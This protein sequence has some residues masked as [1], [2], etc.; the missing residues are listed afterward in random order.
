LSEAFDRWWARE[1]VVLLEAPAPDGLSAFDG[2]LTAILERVDPER[3]SVV[4]VGPSEPDG[5]PELTVAALR[6]P[7][8]EPG[9]LRSAFTR[10]SGVVGLVDVA[11]TLLDQFGIE[12][13][14][15]M[16]G[17]AFVRGREG[18]DYEDR[19]DWLVDT[20]LRARFRDR[21]ITQ[22]NGTFVFC[23]FILAGLVALIF[24]RRKRLTRPL[25][26]A[27]EIAALAL[28]YFLPATYLG[29]LIPFPHWGMAAF[30][31]FLVAFSVSAGALTFALTK[32]T[33]VTPLLVALGAVVGLIVVDQLTGGRLQFNGTF[34]YSPT[35]GGRYAGLGNLGYAQL[36][37]GAALLAGLV[38][39][40]VGGRAGWRFAA[41]ILGIAIVVD[42]APF[43]GA[44]VGGVLSM[45]PAYGVT[46]LMLRGRK[47][48]W[49]TAFGLLAAG[50]AL[51]AIAAAV[52]LTR[53]ADSRSHLGRL[54][55]G[56]GSDVGTV[57]HRKIDANLR[58][59]GATPYTWILPISYVVI[60]YIIWKSPGPLRAARN[61]V[62]ELDASLAGVGLVAL[63]G[64]LLND[65][66]VA[67]T[68]VML[69]VLVPPLVVL[70]LRADPLTA[71]I[72]PTPDIAEIST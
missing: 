42:G 7:G 59:L 65:S 16:E 9:F 31:L 55:A 36:A 44:D 27:F 14:A 72:E 63:L 51:L 20:N 40:Q 66:G 53:P 48:R 30:Y 67:I 56:D 64:T 8:L 68:G 70:C 11:P 34:G 17:R 29:V 12:R 54:L 61:K 23:H 58:V 45:V 35:I 33:G 6:R 15:D 47:L 37:A 32:R 21:A 46:L 57:I 13:P 69:G 24:W 28:L 19:V 49:R 43:F 1:G 39:H 41:A 10:K 5:P 62:R 52:D 26:V 71:V 18:G 3:D 50:V 22:L 25:V 60:A 2:E 4:V 38:A